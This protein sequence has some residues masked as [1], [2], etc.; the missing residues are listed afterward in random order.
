MALAQEREKPFPSSQ[1]KALYW[2]LSDAYQEEI[3]R[4]IAFSQNKQV[5]C[6][7]CSSLSPALDIIISYFLLLKCQQGAVRSVQTD[8]S[9]RRIKRPCAPAGAGSPPVT[10]RM[11]PLGLPLPPPP[12]T[13]G[14]AHPHIHVDASPPSISELDLNKK[15]RII[16]ITFCPKVCV[17]GC[18]RG[19]GGAKKKAKQ[20]QA[21]EST[22]R[23]KQERQPTQDSPVV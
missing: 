7:H 11:R 5:K 13:T 6:L 15:E 9:R 20:T 21:E 16:T 17:L 19:G 12:P 3:S 2:E 1:D 23:G 22:K 18:E 10:E 14:P 4:G 8:R